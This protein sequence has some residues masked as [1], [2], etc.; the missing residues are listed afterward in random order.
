MCRRCHGL[1]RFCFHA[2]PEAETSRPTLIHLSVGVALPSLHPAEP[3]GRLAS[4]FPLAHIFGIPVEETAL[5]AAPVATVLGLLALAQLRRVGKRAT[6][7][8]RAAPGERAPI[9]RWPES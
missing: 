9:R 6:S 3:G 8:K 1:G 2:K 7:L 5:S 4:T